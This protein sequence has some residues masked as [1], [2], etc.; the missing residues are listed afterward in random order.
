MINTFND[1][2]TDKEAI[3]HFRKDSDKY[4]E[5]VEDLKSIKDFVVTE[6]ELFNLYCDCVNQDEDKMR[7]KF[8]LEIG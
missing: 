4:I 6:P 1:I 2:K 7:D 3:K 5:S 8:L